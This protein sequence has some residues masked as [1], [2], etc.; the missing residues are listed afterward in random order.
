MIEF[1]L[2]EERSLQRHLLPADICLANALLT[3]QGMTLY[4][5]LAKDAFGVI[6]TS[7][8]L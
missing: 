2:S 6:S 3:M 4:L 5:P 1:K 7:R 8:I